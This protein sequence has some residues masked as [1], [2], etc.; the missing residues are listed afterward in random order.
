MRTFVAI[1][2]GFLS[3]AMLFLL[4]G[5]AIGFTVSSGPSIAVA[6]AALLA[7]WAVSTYWI[8]VMR[9]PF[10]QCFVVDF[11]LGAVEWFA[12]IPATCSSPVDFQNLPDSAPAILDEAIMRWAEIAMAVG[13]LVAF[14]VLYNARNGLFASF[15]GARRSGDRRQ[16]RARPRHRSGL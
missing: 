10:P 16:P 14:G 5:T 11:L 2:Q 4:A 9:R 15:S 3:A 13:C 7:A 1:V 6:V 8:G 12:L